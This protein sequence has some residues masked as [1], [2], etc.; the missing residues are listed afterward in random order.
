MRN[1]FLSFC[2]GFAAAVLL[3]ST[4]IAVLGVPPTQASDQ[5]AVISQPA[6]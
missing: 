6:E 4:A 2:V 3:G 5:S 1:N